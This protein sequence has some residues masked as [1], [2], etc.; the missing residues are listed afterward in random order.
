MTPVKFRHLGRGC[1]KTQTKIGLRK[2]NAAERATL[3]DRNLGHNKRIPESIRSNR[4]L[5]QPRPQAE[6]CDV[7]KTSDFLSAVCLTAD[8]HNRIDATTRGAIAT[9][10]S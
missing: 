2:I 10:E 7:R 8:L 4:F 1:V 9:R 6:V 3:S 5:T